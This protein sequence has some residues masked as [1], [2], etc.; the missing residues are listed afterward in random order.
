MDKAVQQA[1]VLLDLAFT[2]MSVHVQWENKK[3]NLATKYQLLFFVVVCGDVIVK[4]TLQ[5]H[6]AAK[7]YNESVIIESHGERPPWNHVSKTIEIVG[8]FTNIVMFLD[9]SQ[10]W[11]SMDS[12]LDQLHQ[13][14]VQLFV[15]TNTTHDHQIQVL[16]SQSNSRHETVFVMIGD[17]TMIEKVLTVGKTM[18]RVQHQH[19]YYR[20]LHKWILV[21]PTDQR[22]HQVSSDTVD[23][24]AHVLCMDEGRAR[25]R[26]VA[27][28]RTKL[29][30]KIFGVTSSYWQ[31]P[32]CDTRSLDPHKVCTIERL[33]P[34]TQF[35]MNRDRVRIGSQL[36]PHYVER[37][38]RDAGSNDTYAGM[39]ME[40]LDYLAAYMNFTFEIVIA[41]DGQWGGLDENLSWTGIIRQLQV[42]DVDFAVAPLS[43]T[44]GRR[45]VVDFTDFALQEAYFTG[46]Y[47]RPATGM[48]AVSLYLLPFHADVWYILPFVLL[49]T[50]VAHFLT[51]CALQTDGCCHQSDATGGTQKSQN[52][53][54]HVKVAYNSIAFVVATFFTQSVPTRHGVT[55]N[56]QRVIMG[57]HW[58]FGLLMVSLW[59]LTSSR[60]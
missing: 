5:Q 15:T 60:T 54:K 21:L 37:V 18:D 25:F 56:S 14:S 2:Y 53:L 10:N 52:K 22:C 32:A 41:P 1:L 39:Y 49:A 51:K 42:R 40:V 9:G 3:M 59:A 28:R 44:Y 46:I 26:D 43:A 23:L 16:F 50:A 20:Y 30:T 33:F 45:Q 29:W 38:T 13:E 8:Y 48:S 11:V 24:F 36:W 27:S 4:S 17:V 55:F 47:K 6:Q 19:G 7:L 57:A 12:I 34:N 31:T 58:L 35:G